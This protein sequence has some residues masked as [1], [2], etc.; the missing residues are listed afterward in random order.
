M[1][2]YIELSNGK[3]CVNRNSS[4]RHLVPVSGMRGTT[5]LRLNNYIN[6]LSN[7]SREMEELRGKKGRMR[8]DKFWEK[9]NREV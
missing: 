7:K 1:H 6:Y 8:G 5:S 4:R 3:G 9:S 2:R